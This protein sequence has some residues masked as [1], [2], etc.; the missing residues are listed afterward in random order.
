MPIEFRC[1]QCHK[2]LR[3]NEDKAGLAAQCPG[4]GADVVVPDLPEQPF[5]DGSMDELE[6]DFEENPSSRRRKKCPMCGQQVQPG[7]DRCRNCGELL[8]TEDQGWYS[9]TKSN[10]DLKP[11]RGVVPMVISILSWFFFCFLLAIPCLD[12]GLIRI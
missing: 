1:G 9:P 4:C 6:I 2:L 5:S 12:S 11:H 8:E 3:T 7:A 10:A